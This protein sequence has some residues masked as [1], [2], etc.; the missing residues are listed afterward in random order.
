MFEVVPNAESAEID[1]QNLGGAVAPSAT[2][3]MVE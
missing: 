2:I 1:A 3:V